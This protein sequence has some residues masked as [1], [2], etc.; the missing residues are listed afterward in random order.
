VAACPPRA[1]NIIDRI[2]AHVEH[3]G[4]RDLHRLGHRVKGGSLRFG[5]A[6]ALCVQAHLKMLAEANAMDIGVAIRKRGELIVLTER[7]E[8]R[9]DILKDFN[10]MAP[11]DEMLESGLRE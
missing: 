7:C 1:V 8:R 6:H 4:G 10:L 9:R 2:I 3:L 5:V 11:C